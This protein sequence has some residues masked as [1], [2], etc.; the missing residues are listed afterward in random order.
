MND[1]DFQN[2][3]ASADTVR[4]EVCNAVRAALLEAHYPWH[5]HVGQPELA[6][7]VRGSWMTSERGSFWARGIDGRTYYGVHNGTG[8]YCRMRLSKANRED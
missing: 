2:W 4:A 7:R 6:A 3:N 5:V 1:R 8:T